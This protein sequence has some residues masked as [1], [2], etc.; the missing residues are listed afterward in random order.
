MLLRKL[1]THEDKKID[2]DF[3]QLYKMLDGTSGGLNYEN[4]STN[5]SSAWLS[6]FATTW[7]GSGGT[8]AIGDGSLLYRYMKLGRSNWFAMTLTIG[9]GT[10]VG[11]GTYT[12]TVHATTPNNGMYF[13]NIKGK[14]YDASTGDKYNLSGTIDPNSNILVV[15]IDRTDSTYSLSNVVTAAVPVVPAVGD[16]LTLSGFFESVS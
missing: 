8:P 9:A 12:F 10:T 11:A 3:T 1:F 5:L 15:Q 14:F 13:E 6:T 16:R 4:F 2:Q 7:N